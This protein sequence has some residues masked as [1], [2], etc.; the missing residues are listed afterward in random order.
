M[1]VFTRIICIHN[2]KS[3]VDKKY[4]KFMDYRFL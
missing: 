3:L 4:I 2:M 1:P